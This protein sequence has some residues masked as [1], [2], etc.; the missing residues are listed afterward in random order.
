MAYISKKEVEQLNKITKLK[1]DVSFPFENR[2]QFNL[3]FETWI[4]Q[5]IKDILENN[6]NKSIKKATGELNKISERLK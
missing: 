4:E 5:P 2:E 1:Q 6:L 3:W